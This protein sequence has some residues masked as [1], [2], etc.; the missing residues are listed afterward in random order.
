MKATQKNRSQLQVTSNK[1]IIAGKTEST[2]SVGT[3]MP[4]SAIKIGYSDLLDENKLNLLI[5]Q[6]SSSLALK[7]EGNEIKNNRDLKLEVI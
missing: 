3:T 2:M 5:Q 1:K 6:A 4:R 7:N